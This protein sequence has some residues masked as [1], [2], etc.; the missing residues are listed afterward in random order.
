MGGIPPWYFF[1]SSPDQRYRFGGLYRPSEKMDASSVTTPVAAPAAS[2]PR[3]LAVPFATSLANDPLFLFDL[4][5]FDMIRAPLK[6]RS[7]VMI[8]TGV[9][10]QILLLEANLFIL[11]PVP[12]VQTRIERLPSTP[13]FEPSGIRGVDRTHG[14][15][16]CQES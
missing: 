4:L 3:P 8:T 5:H 2:F 15:A 10:F 6:C 1:C 11:A 9:S 7:L 14:P 16:G 12:S 13:S